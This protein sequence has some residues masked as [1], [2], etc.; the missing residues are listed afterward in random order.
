MNVPGFRKGHA[1]RAFLEKYYGE[2]VFFEAAVDHLYRPMVMEAVEKS[3]LKVVSIGEFK[4]DEIGKE[5]GIKCTITVVT[6]PEASIEATRA[7]KWQK[8]RWSLRR[9]ISTLRS[10]GSESG[11][12]GSS[13]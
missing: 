6:K 5:K 7:L 13:R 10:S 4:I 11:I 8:S 1:P 2:E 12:P 3:E 9:A